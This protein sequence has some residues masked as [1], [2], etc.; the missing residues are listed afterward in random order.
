VYLR[1][2]TLRQVVQHGESTDSADRLR[3][4]A[5]ELGWTE[6]RIV[7]I[8]ETW[9]QSGVRA[10]KVAWPSQR[11]PTRWPTDGWCDLSRGG[12]RGWPEP[13]LNLIWNDDGKCKARTT[14][15][16]RSVNLRRRSS[17][18]RSERL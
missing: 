7:V 6:D 2:S 12:V 9:R 16:I 5:V 17:Q 10:R 8:D 3:Q 11:L 1:Q 13:L 14:P 15:T 18:P 4:R